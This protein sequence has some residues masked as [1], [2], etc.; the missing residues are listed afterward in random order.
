MFKQFKSKIKNQL[1]IK[2]KMIKRDWEW[3]WIQEPNIE[4]NYDVMLT[5][6]KLPWN[7]WGRIFYQEI[8]FWIK[9]LIR[10]WAR[11]RM[12]CWMVNHHPT[13]TLKCGVSR[14]NYSSSIKESPNMDCI[15]WDMKLYLKGITMLI[16]YLIL[17]IQNS[18]I[19]LSLLLEK[20]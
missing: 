7:L 11:Y 17:K 12:S 10:N 16:G 3:C 8:I 19:D 1:S 5:S 4:W 13:N 18:Q 2:I 6:L 20:L 14:K 9:H 15:I